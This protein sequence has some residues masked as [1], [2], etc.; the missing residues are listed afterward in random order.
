MKKFWL[1][2]PA[3]AIALMGAG[4]APAATNDEP[5]DP[6]ADDEDADKTSETVTLPADFPADLPIYPGAELTYAEVSETY[7]D[8]ASFDTSDS[9]KTVYDWYNETLTADGW[10]KT[11]GSEETSISAIWEKDNASITFSA[12]VIG[13]TTSVNIGKTVY[14]Y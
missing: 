10:E 8:S 6:G 11:A 1:F 3:A 2:L 13:N 12:Y 4:C 5:Y 7:G 14:D 9:M